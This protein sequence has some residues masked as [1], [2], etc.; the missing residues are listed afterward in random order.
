MTTLNFEEAA[1]TFEAR[2]V[3]SEETVSRSVSLIE[4]ADG[5]GVAPGNHTTDNST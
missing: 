2:G 4:L 5:C 3:G 1:E